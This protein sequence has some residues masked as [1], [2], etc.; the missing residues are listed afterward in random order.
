VL[1]LLGAA[2]VVALFVGVALRTPKS[3]VGSARVDGPVLSLETTSIDLGR[4]NQSPIV[5]STVNF[6]NTGNADLVI[7]GV[8]ST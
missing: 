4:V 8:H 6:T 1:G 2:C 3:P 7:R 5:A